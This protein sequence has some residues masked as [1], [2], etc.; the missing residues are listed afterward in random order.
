[1]WFLQ[2]AWNKS[3]YALRLLHC[4]FIHYK[5]NL[6]TSIVTDYACTGDDWSAIENIKSEPSDK[7]HLVS[8]DDAFLKK[9]QLLSLLTSGEFVGDKVSIYSFMK[10]RCYSN[11]FLFLLKPTCVHLKL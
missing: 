11:E 3:F 7:R 4:Y 6:I 2:K 8:I 10:R 1:M 9:P 5:I